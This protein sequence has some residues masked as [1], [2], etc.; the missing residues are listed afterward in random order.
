MPYFLRQYTQEP[1]SNDSSPDSQRSTLL[2]F[3]TTEAT[4]ELSEST[5]SK[6]ILSWF[7]RLFS[8]VKTFL[9]YV[10]ILN[11]LPPQKQMS[12]CQNVWFFLF[13]IYGKKIK[14]GRGCLFPNIITVFSNSV[15]RSNHIAS[16]WPDKKSKVSFMY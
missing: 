1:M 7:G 4:P 11:W 5:T 2:Q 14:M 8:G 13:S 3:T 10:F 16:Y 12:K 15:C 9:Q 6:S